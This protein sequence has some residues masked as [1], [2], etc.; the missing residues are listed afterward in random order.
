MTEV[1][2]NRYLSDTS[3]DAERMQIELLRKAGPKGRFKKMASLS[4]SVMVL[5]K[6]AIARQYPDLSAREHALMFISLHFGEEME[7]NV[8]E[9]MRK[10][11]CFE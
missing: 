3:P 5:S 11:G 7:K 6:R 10:R 9:Y 2:S 8:R 1:P 4:H